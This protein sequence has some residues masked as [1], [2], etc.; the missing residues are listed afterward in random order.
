MR[1]EEDETT[2]I[3]VVLDHVVTARKM[4][5]V[6]EALDIGVVNP[7]LTPLPLT[8]PALPHRYQRLPFRTDYK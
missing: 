6:I 1:R 7:P 4:I 5:A 2:E 8:Q 3:T